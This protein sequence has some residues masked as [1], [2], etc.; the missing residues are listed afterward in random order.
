MAQVALAP[1][2]QR[3]PKHFLSIWSAQT[4][5][6]A[7]D[8]IFFAAIA[9]FVT[10]SHGP[11][12]GTVALGLAQFLPSAL[13]AP[14]GGVLVD[15]LPRFWLLVV[16]DFSRFALS[17]ALAG[18]FMLQG[19]SVVSVL[20]AVVLLRV[21][22]LLFQPALQSALGSIARDE[23]Q[24]IRLDAWVLASGMAAG[25]LGPA[26]AGAAVT[27]GATIA[28]LANGATFLVSA[29]TLLHAKP[30]LTAADSGRKADLGGAFGRWW[31]AAAEGVATAVADPV[32]RRLAPT[33]PI[34]DMVAA[35]VTL[36]LPTMLLDQGTY[37][38]WWYG[39][40]IWL[41]AGG[42]F[43]G[44]FLTRRLLAT[45]GRGAVLALNAVLQGVCILSLSFISVPVA[46]LPVFFL[47]GIPSGCASVC[48]SAYVQTRIPEQ[49]RGRVFA[50]LGA[51]VAVAMPLGP[52]VGGLVAR[53]GS[54]GLAFAV[55]GL[56]LILVGLGPLTSRR[57]WS[58]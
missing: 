22:G 5:S 41:W 38:G 15:R 10:A 8:R 39:A 40:L 47:L 52:V 26:L 28:M 54:T 13:L 45:S 34:I 33:L 49:A 42:R 56:V 6:A 24:L 55:L 16:S 37:G 7:G 1:A 58:V 3:L 48:V 11:M 36:L 43:T 29:I 50:L 53:V 51:V 21:A 23:R 32:M 17:V 46:M 35:G 19:L 27:A 2:V 14:F 44:L 31:H 20:V 57:V 18:V 25:L 9:W 12:L 30:L 4:L